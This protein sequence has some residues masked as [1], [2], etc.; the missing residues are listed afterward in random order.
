MVFR[1]YAYTIIFYLENPVVFFFFS[2]NM[3]YW[4]I[5]GIFNGINNKILKQLNKL[6]VISE[7]PPAMNHK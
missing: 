2:R 3:D 7:K 1:I 5:A 4:I 6:I